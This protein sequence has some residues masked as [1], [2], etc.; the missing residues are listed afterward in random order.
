MAQVKRNPLS[1]LINSFRNDPKLKRAAPVDEGVIEESS[2]R[3]NR[4][5]KPNEANDMLTSMM[6]KLLFE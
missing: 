6:N 3:N 4:K 1:E 5:L 2:K